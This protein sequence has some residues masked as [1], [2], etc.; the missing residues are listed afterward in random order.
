MFQAAM[1]AFAG[2]DDPLSTSMRS[3]RGDRDRRPSTMRFVGR[4]LRGDADGA[5]R[6]ARRQRKRRGRTRSAAALGRCPPDKRRLAMLGSML[7]PVIAGA[8]GRRSHAG[9]RRGRRRTAPALRPACAGTLALAAQT[10]S[11]NRQWRPVRLSIAAAGRR[12][13]CLRRSGTPSHVDHART[14]RSIRRTGLVMSA[15]ESD[16]TDARRDATAASSE[17]RRC[18]LDTLS[19]IIIPARYPA[20]SLDLDLA[21][22][23]IGR[24][25]APLVKGRRARFT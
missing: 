9:Q 7:A 10:V 24:P 20:H 6:H 3:G 18:S 22:S 13:G 12:A 11:R 15:H 19:G 23:S 25:F 4:G 1:G 21:P 5:R 8:T 2:Q 16:R 17:S 14:A